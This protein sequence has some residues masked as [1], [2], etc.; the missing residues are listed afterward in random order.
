MVNVNTGGCEGVGLGCL[1]G[2]G[3]ISSENALRF[4][5]WG[6]GLLLFVLG[7]ELASDALEELIVVARGLEALL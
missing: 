4:W 6:L 3:D 7:G 2:F 1:D 5:G